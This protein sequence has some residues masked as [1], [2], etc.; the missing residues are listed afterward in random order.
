MVPTSTDYKY[1]FHLCLVLSSTVFL[2]RFP[3]SAALRLCFVLGDTW[4]PRLGS[5]S[6]PVPSRLLGYLTLQQLFWTASS[7]EWSGPWWRRGGDQWLLTTLPA[8]TAT[9][10][11]TD[12][13][14]TKLYRKH[15]DKNKSTHIGA[16][17]TLV[18]SFTF[19]EFSWSQSPGSVEVWWRVEVKAWTAVQSNGWGQLSGIVLLRR[20]LWQRVVG[21][22]NKPTLWHFSNGWIWRSALGVF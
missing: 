20:K 18:L 6:L 7:D 10:A 8:C 12:K 21:R 2:T 16:N 22:L 4:S 9:T 14:Q 15:N 13:K 3:D 5:L 11:W 1:C 19:P 17:R